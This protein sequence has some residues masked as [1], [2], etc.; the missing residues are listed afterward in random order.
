MK[1]KRRFSLKLVASLLAVCFMLNTVTISPVNAKTTEAIKTNPIV[2]QVTKTDDNVKDKENPAHENNDKPSNEVTSDSSYKEQGNKLNSK[3]NISSTKAVEKQKSTTTQTM[4]SLPV[5]SKT[6]NVALAGIMVKENNN[7]EYNDVEKNIADIPTKSGIWIPKNQRSQILK[8]VNTYSAF[9]FSTD[10]EGY[11]C[12]DKNVVEDTTK[13]KIF[14]EKF[15]TLIKGNERVILSLSNSFWSYDNQTL[16]LLKKNI[17]DTESVSF[18]FNQSRLV[19]LN[20]KSFE[21]TNKNLAAQAIMLLKQIFRDGTDYSSQINNEIKESSDT[22]SSSNASSSEKLPNKTAESS[23][24]TSASS[25]KL[26]SST[27]NSSSQSSSSSTVNSSKTSSSSEVVSSN[28]ATSNK[29]NS[30]SSISSSSQNSTST[31]PST[32]SDANKASSSINSSSKVSE[33]PNESN[34]KTSSITSTSTNSKPITSSDTSSEK[35]KDNVEK[36]NATSYSAL[37]VALAGTVC[38]KD[39][40][41]TSDNIDNNLKAIPS[42]NGVWVPSNYRDSILSLINEASSKPFIISVDGYLE[43]KDGGISDSQKSSV[44]TEKLLLLIKSNQRVILAPT[45]KIWSY[46]SKV[47]VFFESIFGDTYSVQ[48]ENKNSRLILLNSTLFKKYDYKNNNIIVSA[49]L[50]DQIFNDGIDY[51]T[52]IK[53]PPT[54]S[55]LSINPVATSGTMDS[56]QTTY[57]GP[58]NSSIYAKAGS[59]DSGESVSVINI[60]QGW[61]YIEYNTSGGHKRGYVPSGTVSYSGSLPTANYLDGYYN[62]TLGNT[63]IYYLNSATGITVGTVYGG[64]GIT[65]LDTAS[66]VSFIEYSSSSGTK[67]GYVANSQLDTRSD[68][69]VGVVTASSTSVYSGTDTNFYRIGSIGQTEYSVLLEDN[70][71]WAFVEYNTPSGRKRGYTPLSNIGSHNSTSAIPNIYV[72]R[73]LGVANAELTA[74]CGPNSN[75]AKLGTVY[76]GDQVNIITDNEYGRALVEYYTGNHA[77]KRGYVDLNH[78]QHISLNSIPTPSGG[79]LIK[80]GTSEEGKPLNAYKLGSGS[81]VLFAVFA[82]HGFEDGWAADGIELV[83]VANNLISELGGNGN[84][85]KWTIY[86]IPSANPDGLLD[87]YTNNGHGRCTFYGTDMNRSHNTST[88]AYYTD[89]R[90]KTNNR[91]DE[92]VALEDFVKSRKSSEGQNVLLDV[93][94]W[95]NSTLGDPTISKYFGN[96]LGLR[97]V[98]DGGSTGYLITWGAQNNIASVL[99]EL[100]FTSN[101]A[102]LASLNVSGKFNS[103][104]NNLLTNS[105]YDSGSTSNVIGC[106]D[107]VSENYVSGWAKDTN[108]PSDTIYVDTYIKN[109]AGTNVFSERVTANNYRADVAPGSHGYRVAMDWR[110]FAPGTYKVY[111]YGIGKNG[112]N[113]LLTNAPLTYTVSAPT[114]CVDYVDEGGIGGWVWKSSAPNKPI[115]VK[116]C[117]NNSDG[118]TVWSNIVNANQYRSDLDRLGYGNGYH[119]FS[120]NVPWKFI[121]G[122]SLK[123]NVFAVDASGSYQIYCKDYSNSDG[124]ELPL[125]IYQTEHTLYNDENGIQAEDLNCGDKSL[126]ELKSIKGVNYKDDETANSEINT[127]RNMCTT[128]F[129]KDPLET[130]INDM[131]NHFISGTGTSYSNKVLTQK[132]IEHDSTQKYIKSVKSEINEALKESDGNIG[133]LRYS[134]E[135]RGN[136]PLVTKLRRDKVHEPVFNTFNDK[137]EG[138]TICVDGLWGNLIQVKSYHLDGN[139]YSG[140]LHFTLYDHF[141]LDEA[142]VNKYGDIWT[143]FS[144]W[145]ILQHLN[146]YNQQYKPFLTVIEFDESFSGTLN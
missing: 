74:Y 81:N 127:W 46:D 28:I 55:L 143:G 66:G 29:T 105:G 25:S 6:F 94:G 62:A 19:I 107:A 93:H 70:G 87:G 52:I 136:N 32:A 58:G 140:V 123:I 92:V 5:S 89:S 31:V 13:S 84:L 42:K 126:S 30:S 64:E 104:I 117:V 118:D 26:T 80:Y 76:S 59:V 114:G 27:I 75:Y 73:N 2:S 20:S 37:D 68:G 3:N 23:S 35:V 103:A 15:I 83:K 21:I 63:S 130:V 4:I 133:A 95:E 113:P 110:T 82:Q 134:S 141:G 132:A 138:L 49:L 22:P 79:S 50:F 108:N 97:H 115:Q 88:L 7:L 17:S 128:T 142:D 56:A 77:S 1:S 54:F 102:A 111:S 44:I 65:V 135:D 8:L 116:V 45:E 99:V 91:A 10:N 39:N 41:L 144:S 100:P 43:L 131:I 109:S 9:K 85:S 14:A 98:S 145:Y 129:S 106:M 51:S 72:S 12:E 112:N 101:A 53:I 40:L 24:T 38:K 86:V 69:I 137:L 96:A 124:Y 119:G 61:V 34:V 60:E 33:A 48:F 122:T 146:S 57:M 18:K 36:S 16:R 120:V 139:T 78:I 125:I 67:R 71:I 90:N 11:L 121:E 47:N